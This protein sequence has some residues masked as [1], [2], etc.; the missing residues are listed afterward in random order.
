M[1]SNG[2]EL[3]LIRG[4]SKRSTVTYRSDTDHDHADPSLPAI[5][6]A[7]DLGRPVYERLGYRFVA[8]CATVSA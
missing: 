3:R 1:V 7:S 4:P 2:R 5:L 6:I 8:R